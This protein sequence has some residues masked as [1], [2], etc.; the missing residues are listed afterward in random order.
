MQKR[1]ISL[2]H[3]FSAKAIGLS[4]EDICFSHSKPHEKALRKLQESGYTVYIDYFTGHFIPFTKTINGV[5]K[6][7]WP[8][9]KPIFKKRHG[10]RKQHSL[11]HYWYCI[12]R[13]PDVTIIN[14]SAHGS[15][16]CFKLA[17]LL[18]KKHKPYL[19]MIGG[20]N[21]S[22]TIQAKQY[23]QNA[24]HIIVHTEVQKKQLQ[25]TEIFK[26]LTIRV[27]PLGIDTKVFIPKER[28]QEG[29]E[30]LYVGRISRL[31]QIE[32]CLE[33]LAYLLQNQNKEIHLNVVGPI[34]DKVY[35]S[36]LQNL[37]NQ[38]QVTAHITFIGSIAQEEL[39]PFYQKASLLLLPSAHESFGMVMVEAMAC[40]TP[41][42]ALK[43]AGG[44]D[45]LIEDGFNGF[46]C[47]KNNFNTKVSRVLQ[48]Q[49]LWKNLSSN[50]R[51]S[52]IDKWS[53][54]VTIACLE[55]SVKSA[56]N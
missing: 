56:L 45:E 32:F 26:D 16:Y 7:F 8:I 6:R 54:N 22:D 39:V 29:I 19:A 43:G 48:D 34:S 33:A 15:P 52:V 35:Y 27:M 30:L 10:W 17:N 31:K 21:F 37:A 14:V 12:F 53:L 28:N 1:Y 13:A 20:V 41:V 24:H 25:Q 44:P 18:F 36:E 38:L 55:E 3:P 50:A 5:K 46:L 49:D 2:L 40:G 47:E 11:L 4:E 51:Q 42:I 23:Y 9:T